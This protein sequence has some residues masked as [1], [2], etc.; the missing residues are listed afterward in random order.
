MLF[1]FLTKRQSF[2]LL[3]W[4]L[5]LSRFVY[6]PHIFSNHFHI[7]L[8]SSLL[9]F[10][11]NSNYFS[12]TVLHMLHELLSVSNQCAFNSVNNGARPLFKAITPANLKDNE[13]LDNGT[14]SKKSNHSVL[15]LMTVFTVT[16]WQFCYKNSPNASHYKDGV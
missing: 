13:S 11:S 16:S 8:R 9:S 4:Q 14:E 12:I 5:M 3:K 1:Y 7:L 6:F 2:F 15:C 10:F